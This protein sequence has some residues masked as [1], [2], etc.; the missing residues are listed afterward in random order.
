[1][2]IAHKSTMSA[3]LKGR[4]DK[5]PLEKILEDNASSRN[6][7]AKVLGT[8]SSILN[9]DGCQAVGGEWVCTGVKV[10]LASLSLQTQFQ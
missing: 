6:N 2:F 8:N 3:I 1:M 5:C 4:G 10:S 7:C 9:A